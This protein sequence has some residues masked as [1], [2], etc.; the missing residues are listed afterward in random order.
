MMVSLNWLTDYVDISL[1]VTDLGEL[2]TQIGLNL[3]GIVETDTDIVLDLEVTS[4]RSDCLGHLGVAREIA[5]ATG[6]EFRMPKIPELPTSGAAADYASVEVQ[7]PDLCPRYT[8][9]VIRGVK[10]GPSPQWLIERL[11]AIGMRSVN[12]IVDVTNYVLMEYSQP[13]HSFDHDKLAG[14]RIV[15]R[16]GLPGEVMTSIDQT[17]CHLDE[18]MCV[19]AD[20]EKAVAIAGIM[21]GLDSEVTESTTNVLIEA[22]QFDPLT[23]RH[24]S[25]KLQLM[26]ESNYR[27]ERGIDP[28]G[29]ERA[30]LRA[31]QL[32]LELAGGALAGGMVDIWSDPW[33]GR[34]VTLRPARCNALLGMDIPADEQ[35]EILTR[36]GLGAK[37]D[38]ETITCQI[39]PNRADLTREADL[40]E[41]VAR[42][43]GYNNIPVSDKVTHTLTAETLETRTRR[44]VGEAM[45]A[46]G[47]DEAVTNTFI[48]AEEAKLFGW[49]RCVSVDP[50]NRKTNNALRP[51]VLGNLLRACKTNQDAGNGDVHLFELAGV[52]EP[53]DNGDLPV[54]HVELGIVSLGELSRLRGALEALIERIA[55]QAKLEVRSASVAGFAEDAAARIMLDGEKIGKLGMIDPAV[56][57]H[58]DLSTDRNIAAAAVCFEAIRAKAGRGKTYQ[59]MPKFPAIQR[60]LSVIVDGEVTWQ[61]LTDAIAQ[62]DQPMR[63]ATDY[64]TTYT[65]K[66]IGQGRKSVTF[67]LTYRS[68]ETT[69]RSEQVDAEVDEIISAL[70]KKFDAELRA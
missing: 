40:I 29:L 59:G 55:P 47:F 11:E 1:P 52:F 37:L 14:G 68:D 43:A 30:S 63:Q 58:Y 49:S 62:I 67:Q 53:G 16:R 57:T 25:R 24:T 69:L 44:T 6:A 17:K 10:V 39:P 66:Q 61:D 41:E 19:I 28:V 70:K 36:L 34:T 33:Q 4:N 42:L 65:G 60:D 18:N 20:A 23:T 45:T 12:N 54:E 3:E 35:A 8:A 56:L 13:L 46:A 7:C 50:S 64:V 27:F 9:R 51:T 5:A 21:G 32:I 31:C 2:L 15:V 26:S 48:D 38:G 22:A